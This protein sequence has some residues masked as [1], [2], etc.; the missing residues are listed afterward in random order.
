M[1]LEQFEMSVFSVGEGLKIGQAIVNENRQT[2]SE[3]Q[4]RCGSGFNCSGGGGQC[5]S[6]F[7][8]GGGGGKCGS[9]FNCGGS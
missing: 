9:G 2:P 7:N 8:C 6:G 5:G 1:K 3:A 4:G